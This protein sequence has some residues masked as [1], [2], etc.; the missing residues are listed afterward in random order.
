MSSMR[1]SNGPLSEANEVEGLAELRAFSDLV[2]NAMKRAVK[3]AI[4]SHHRAGNPV[5]QMTEALNVD[6]TQY[7]HGTRASE[8]ERLALLNRLTNP[9]FLE[10]LNLQP[11]DDVLEVGSGLGI[12]ANEAAQDLPDG[13]VTGIEYSQQQ[14]GSA[15]ILA[16]NVRFLRGDAHRLPFAD[17]LF[18]VSANPIRRNFIQDRWIGHFPL[19][20]I[21]FLFPTICT[22]D[23]CMTT[24]Q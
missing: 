14:I 24:C 15:H 7:I 18:D 6:R 19:R 9:P 10:F 11:T 12:L 22:I 20:F 16:P 2:E 17:D 8:Q 5:A 4:A 1:Q 21:D 13:R 23:I 3:E